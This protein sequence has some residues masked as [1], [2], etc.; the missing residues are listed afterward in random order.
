M[1]VQDESMRPTLQPGDRLLVDPAAFRRD[2]PRVGN[3]IVVQDPEAAGRWLVKR[4]GGRTGPE[5]TVFLLGDNPAA[6]RDSRTFGPVSPDTVVGRPWFRY[7]PQDRRGP[8]DG[9]GP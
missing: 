8:L 4:V 1:L 7:L 5:R 2:P 3:L 6:S 9:D